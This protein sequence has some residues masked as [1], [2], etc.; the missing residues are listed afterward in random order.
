MHAMAKRIRFIYWGVRDVT[1]ER[2]PLSTASLRV[3]KSSL[4]AGA[5]TGFEIVRAQI[6]VTTN[7][8]DTN[9]RIIAGFS[10]R[11]LILHFNNIALK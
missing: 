7:V 6:H 2:R 8:H 9:Y 1:A 3:L 11:N 10:D 5:S 4:N